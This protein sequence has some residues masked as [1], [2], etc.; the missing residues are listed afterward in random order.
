MS[1]RAVLSKELLH[2]VD[3]TCPPPVKFIYK[4]FIFACD[5]SVYWNE[6]LTAIKNDGSYKL[7]LTPNVGECHIEVQD[8]LVFFT[9]A[10]REYGCFMSFCVK[11]LL[12]QNAFTE[13]VKI[14]NE[15]MQQK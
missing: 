6:V 15:W 10:K 1:V 13:A 4:E 12:C 8:G 14:T 2:A 11:N 5:G 3:R 9:M 7:N